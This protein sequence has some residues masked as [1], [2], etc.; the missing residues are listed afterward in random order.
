MTTKRTPLY[1]G[2]HSA[3]AAW[4]AW[5]ATGFDLA[6]LLG[7]Y[8]LDDDDRDPRAQAA[9]RGGGALGMGRIRHELHAREKFR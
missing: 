1:R 2:L 6:G 4:G 9:L 8:G 3:G 7:P 5:F